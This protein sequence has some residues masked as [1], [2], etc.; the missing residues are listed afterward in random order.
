MEAQGH[1]PVQK[2]TA[3]GFLQRF[4]PGALARDS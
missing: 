1:Q 4:A 3:K 2:G